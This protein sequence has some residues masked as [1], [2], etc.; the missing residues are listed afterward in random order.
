MQAALY[1]V[2]L[3][4][5]SSLEAILAAPVA[6]GGKSSSVANMLYTHMHCA[7]INQSLSKQQLDWLSS[8]SFKR[9]ENLFVIWLISLHC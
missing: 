3:F 8:I 5:L 6:S 7:C 9:F 1:L 4:S 2:T